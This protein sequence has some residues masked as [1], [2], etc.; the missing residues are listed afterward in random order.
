MR[1]DDERDQCIDMLFSKVQALEKEMAMLKDRP[2]EKESHL[3]KPV[4][5]IE[6]PDAAFV[7]RTEP[8][9]AANPAIS[10]S[11]ENVIGAR[12]IGRIGVLAIIFGVAFFLKYS[13]DNKLIGETGRIVLG[14]IWGAVFIGAGEYL[15]KKKNLGL[16]GQML[17]GCGLAVLYLA[18][19]AAFALY[20][21][22]PLPLAAIAMIAVTTTGMTLS[23]RYSTSSLAAIAL[24]GG[25]LTPIMISTGQNQPLFLFGYILLLD[26]GTLLLVRFRQWP[27]LVAAS[28]LG[29][30][31]LYAGWH[32]DFFTDA[33]RWFAAAVILL[34]FILYN[35]HLLLFRP[36]AEDHNP[37]FDQMIIFGSAAFF[38]LA[39]FSQYSWVNAWP[40]KLLALGLAAVEV[41]LAMLVDE[42]DGHA[43]IKKAS[44]AAV[45]GI[46]TVI[47][48]FLVLE[49][50]WLL[51]ALAAEMAALAWI[52]LKK[53]LP[54]MRQA[55]GLL[56]LLV[57]IRFADDLNLHFEP[58]Q[59]FL[60]VFNGRFL[61][62]AFAVVCF[63]VCL[64]AMKQ[65][66]ENLAAGER[67]VLKILFAVTQALSLL[68]LSVEM[69]DFF[70]SRSPRHVLG[71]ADAN[72][73]YQLS[74]S[75]LWALYASVLTGVGILKRLRE[76]RMLGIL[77][78]GVTVL[79]VFLIDLSRL[80]TFYRIISFIVLGLLL[81]AVSYGYH[82]FKH[83]IFGENEP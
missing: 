72:Y 8:V 2:R 47:A 48:T 25:F 54:G 21:L 53:D 30:A 40:V 79:K 24:L 49:Q 68:L 56:S 63:Y 65:H 60:P 16:Y 55:A 39:Y 4:C 75:V 52:G 69:H 71:Y 64:Y 38:F 14:I 83:L 73:A 20:H 81:L 22:L 61:S 32:A 77:L 67:N 19:Y 10:S 59:T 13:F 6:I 35:L 78:L 27:A 70:R 50:R 51:P 7:C 42:N 29:T 18:L 74:L 80:D 44:Y 3:N 34:F 45:S 26:M 9:I 57:L 36:N 23:I 1:S 58:F 12:W 37:L 62:C 11:L 31:L 15:Q 17:S 5:G 33:Q 82:R 28:L 43:S 76:A 66:Q 41:C 46:M